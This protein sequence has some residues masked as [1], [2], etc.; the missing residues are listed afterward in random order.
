MCKLCAWT[1]QSIPGVFSTPTQM[2]SPGYEARPKV[3]VTRPTKCHVLSVKL[4][5][6][7][8]NSHSHTHNCQTGSLSHFNTLGGGWSKEQSTEPHP[9]EL[10]LTTLIS[11]LWLEYWYWL[12][13]STT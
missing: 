5:H 12:Q 7:K 10:I 11:R 13:S 4:T 8:C 3:D 2:K 6:L 9:Q 1:L